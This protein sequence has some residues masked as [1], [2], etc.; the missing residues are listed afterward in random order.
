MKK[1]CLSVLSVLLLLSLLLGG[2]AA[3]T[4][5]DTPG[6]DS[7]VVRPQYD[8]EFTKVSTTLILNQVDQNDCKGP[9]VGK[10]VTVN[11]PIYTGIPV[12]AVYE[13]EELQCLSGVIRFVVNGTDIILDNTGALAEKPENRKYKA[14][15]LPDEWKT[16]GWRGNGVYIEQTGEPGSY[17]QQLFNKSGEAISEQFDSIG[18]FYNGIAIIVEDYKIGLIAESGEVLL[19]PSIPMDTVVYDLDAKQTGISFTAYMTEDTFVLPVGGELAIFT[20]TRE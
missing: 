14:D 6:T 7:S 12:D 15:Y 19:E 1:K 3:K 5:D 4:P 2:C 8:V 11:A 16:N 17:R 18:Y 10:G 13:L 9:F 20:L